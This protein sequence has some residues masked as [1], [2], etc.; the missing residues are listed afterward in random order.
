MS[1]SIEQAAYMDALRSLSDRQLFEMILPI[2]EHIKQ[3]HYPM[4]MGLG[5]ELSDL[6]KVINERIQANETKHRRPANEHY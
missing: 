5:D 2:L 6:I 1:E 4:Q 3:K